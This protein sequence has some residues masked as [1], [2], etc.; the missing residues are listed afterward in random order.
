MNF[1]QINIVFD[2]LITALSMALENYGSHSLIHGQRCAIVA[3]K[4]ASKL[5]PESSKDVFYAALL[6]D[7]GAVDA[8]SHISYKT[9]NRE[10]LHAEIQQHPL[11]RAERYLKK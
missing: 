6:H 2:E 8:E 9:F 5:Y 1:F 11:N 10:L 7:I 3:E 4:I